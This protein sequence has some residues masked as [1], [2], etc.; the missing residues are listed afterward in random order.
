[1]S[2]QRSEEEIIKEAHEYS[3]ALGRREERREIYQMVAVEHI[4]CILDPDDLGVS[5]NLVTMKEIEIQAEAIYQGMIR[6]VGDK[7]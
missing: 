5:V 3:D 4:G 6:F 2:K 7:T 1:M